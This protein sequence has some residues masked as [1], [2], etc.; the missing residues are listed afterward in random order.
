MAI[1]KIRVLLNA[2]TSINKMI[3]SGSLK[4]F[5]YWLPDGFYNVRRI[6]NT[7]DFNKDYK[8]T[9]QLL[10][11][12][13]PHA[14]RFLILDEIDKYPENFLGKPLKTGERNDK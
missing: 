4:C 5:C 11:D 1:A 9:K 12:K 13:N 8:I 2:P 3:K 14:R 7:G 10:I 6:A